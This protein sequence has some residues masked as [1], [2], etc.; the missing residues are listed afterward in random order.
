MRVAVS[1]LA[2]AHLLGCA[3]AAPRPPGEEVR[4]V[5]VNGT[6]IAYAVDGSG[7]LVVIVHGAFGD[8]RSFSRSA[9]ILARTR[10]VVRVSLRL[11]WPNPWPA[12]EQEATACYRVENHAADVAALIERLGGPADLLGHSYGGVVAALVARSRPDL[13]RR[14]ILVEPSLHGLLRETAAGAKILEEDR[15]DRDERLAELRAGKKPLASLRERVGPD[16]FDAFPDVRRRIIADNAR[17]LGPILV[18][19]WTDLPYACDD[20]RRLTMPVLLVE[21][22]RTGSEM[23]DIDSA[24]LRCLPDAR[25]IVLPDTGHAIQFDAPEAM[26]RAVARFVGR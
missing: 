19:G 15:R 22:A 18:H 5:E 20:A 9:S 23:R 6:E 11:H 8:L 21:G 10:R 7:P 1:W 24:L 26:A 3:S 14:L 16:R 12:S 25:K 4:R 13:V 2:A 17:T